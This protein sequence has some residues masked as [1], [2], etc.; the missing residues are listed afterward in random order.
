MEK[1]NQIFNLTEMC[2]NAGSADA[3][4]NLAGKKHIRQTFQH[5]QPYVRCSNKAL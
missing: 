1:S 5:G 4:F 2:F 3:G